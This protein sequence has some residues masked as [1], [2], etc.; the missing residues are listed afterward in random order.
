MS[1]GGILQ[2]ILGVRK[3]TYRPQPTYMKNVAQNRV[4]KHISPFIY[5]MISHKSPQDQNSTLGLNTTV[6]VNFS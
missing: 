4:K 1:Y 3:L 2:Q 5:K 6:N